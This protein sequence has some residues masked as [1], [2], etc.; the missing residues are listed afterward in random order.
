MTTAV[1]TVVRK[2]L[3]KVAPYGKAVVPPT[4]N[5]DSASMNSHFCLL[6]DSNRELV[7]EYL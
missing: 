4:N 5:P 2:E 7:V 6:T 3:E 1:H